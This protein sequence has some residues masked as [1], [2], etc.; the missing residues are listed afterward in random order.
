[1]DAHRDYLALVT[2]FYEDLWN[3]ADDEALRRILA[4]EVQFKGSTE[5][6]VRCGPEAFRD[7]R[8]AIRSTL[9]N[10]TCT[11]LMLEIMFLSTRRGLWLVNVRGLARKP[12]LIV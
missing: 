7:Y 10:Y 1:M 11:T 3:K 4:P 12:V 6:Q 5:C 9:A 8:N 2:A